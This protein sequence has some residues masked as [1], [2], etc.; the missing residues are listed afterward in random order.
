MDAI[1]Q[2]HSIIQF[3]DGEIAQLEGKVTLTIRLGCL[4]GPGVS[5]DFYVFKD[6][7]C[8]L[9]LGEDFLNENDAFR[10]YQDAFK[11]ASCDDYAEF[12]TIRWSGK[13]ESFL[14]RFNSRSN[15]NRSNPVIC[16]SGPGELVLRTRWLVSDS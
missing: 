14:A 9:L 4:S 15:G 12:N 7:T 10:T 2:H 13:V 8:D 16:T 6:L 1:N 3:T 11:I 5:I